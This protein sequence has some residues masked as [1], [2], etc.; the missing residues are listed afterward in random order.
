MPT[1]PLPRIGMTFDEFRQFKPGI[2]PNTIPYEGAVALREHLYTIDGQWVFTFRENVMHRIQFLDLN[3]I[4][5]KTDFETWLRSAKNVIE[6]FTR[7]FGQPRSHQRGSEEYYDTNSRYTDK[8]DGPRHTYREVRWAFPLWEINIICEIRSSRAEDAPDKEYDEY[9]MEFWTYEF[10]IDAFVFHYGLP[11]GQP[12]INGKYYIG[13]PVTAFAER[14]PALFPNGTAPSGIFQHKESWQGLNGEWTYHFEAG[15]LELFHFHAYF[16]NQEATKPAFQLCM[17]ATTAIVEE[18]KTRFGKPDSD[19]TN[20]RDFIIPNLPEN[21]YHYDIVTQWHK[22]GGMA[23]KVEF[24][25]FYGSGG[26]VIFN[27]SVQL[28]KKA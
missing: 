14:H 21:T 10:Q 4:R 24:Y 6:D 11:S 5:S 23:V 19:E 8:P 1:T 2:L 15:K 17:R 3:Q 28:N 7:T 20:P 12:L 25:R 26:H 18:F 13:M 16:Y 22:T 9:D 27:V